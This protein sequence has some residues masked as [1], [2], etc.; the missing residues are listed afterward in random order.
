M[1]QFYLQFY[2]FS[3][4]NLISFKLTEDDGNNS[5]IGQEIGKN[6]QFSGVFRG[7]RSGTLVENGLEDNRLEGKFVCKNDI[8]LLQRQLTKL[9]ISL[10]SE[11]RKVV[12]S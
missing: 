9:E 12:P 5:E 6:L 8:N 7:Y 2:Y 10:L 4:C 1:V 3:T 11:G